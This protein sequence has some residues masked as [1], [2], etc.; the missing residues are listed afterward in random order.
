M[1]RLLVFALPLLF[2]ITGCAHLISEQSRDLVDQT[3]TF[4]QL[5]GNPKAYRGK[6]VLLGG[7]VTAVTKTGE[8]TQLEI[9]EH[10]LDSRELP[11]EVI[12]SRGSF[13]AVTLEPLDSAKYKPGAL[14]SMLGEVTGKKA[15][16][17]GGMEYG[18][19]VIVIREIYA[20]EYMELHPEYDLGS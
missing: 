7:N 14:V 2:L 16:P 3:I 1:R 19:P 15:Y 12:A 13:L 20:F 18:Y 5:R 10:W 11:V 6:L 17:L 4:N 9:I 8:E